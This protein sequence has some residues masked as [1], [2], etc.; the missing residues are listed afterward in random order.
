MKLSPYQKKTVRH[1]FDSLCRKVLRDESRNYK[2]QLARRAEK[3][4]NFSGLSEVELN[5]LYVMDEYPSDSTYFDVLDYQIAVKDGRLA[6]AL[7][8]LPSKKRDVILL[9][10]FLDMTD[11]EIAEKLEVVGSTIHR[12]RTSSL[13]ELKLRLE[14]LEDGQSE[15]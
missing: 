15:E 13:E 11:T 4:A 3:E 7:A 6:E 10:Y 12:R 14:V 1:Q 9:S 2:K 5:Q 8:A